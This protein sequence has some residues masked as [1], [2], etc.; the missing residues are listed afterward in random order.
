MSRISLTLRAIVF[1]TIMW[2]LFY[3]GVLWATIGVSEWLAVFGGIEDACFLIGRGMV[4]DWRGRCVKILDE[5]GGTLLM[6]LFSDV[7]DD[8]VGSDGKAA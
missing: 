8:G 4:P 7:W 6:V 2:P 5:N 1:R 3:Q